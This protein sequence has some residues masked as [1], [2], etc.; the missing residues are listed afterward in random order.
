MKL[1]HNGYEINYD[2]AGSGP[3]LVLIHGVG[4]SLRSWDHVVE[5]LG[6]DYRVLRYDTLGHGDSEKPDGPYALDDY[7]SESLALLDA[8]GIESANIIGSSFGGMIAQAFAITHPQR[9]ATVALLSAVAARTPEQ[10]AAVIERADQLA[11]GGAERT[12]GAALERWYTPEFRAKH[13]DLLA[14]QA[15]RVKSND[16]MGYAAAYRVFAESDLDQELSQIRAPTLIVTGE[17]DVGSTPEMARLMHERIPG[18]RLE[19]LP[20]LRHGI[21]VEAPDVVAD[22]LRDFLVQN[23]AAPLPARAVFIRAT[24]TAN[25]RLLAAR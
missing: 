18:S 9:V 11:A 17:H 13:Q 3:P 12:V 1:R 15:E 4:S 25:N 14:Q 24:S 22:L 23:A 2:V 8:E 21:L 16:P 10:R 20:V 19:I 5:R 7:V 6:D